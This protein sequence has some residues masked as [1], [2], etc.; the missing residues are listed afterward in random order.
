MSSASPGDD[1]Q[2]A[3]HFESLFAGDADPWHYRSRWY[4]RRKRDLTLACLP[5]ARYANAFEPACAIG[6][7]SAQLAGRCDQLLSTDGSAAA[8]AQA[9]ERLA[10]FPHL[11]VERATVPSAWPVGRFDL[12]VLSEFCYYLTDDE[13]EGVIDRSAA[14]LALGGTVIACHWR[15]P[16][17]DYLRL[18]DVVHQTLHQRLTGEHGMTR[19]MRHEEDDFLIDVWSDDGRS[20]ASREGVPQ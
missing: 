3:Q 6:E 2:R 10:E 12:I 1:D 9:R 11:Q 17:G 13:F 18:G 4:E 7:L 5:Q 14:S 8:I 16:E 15:H 20:V 19:L